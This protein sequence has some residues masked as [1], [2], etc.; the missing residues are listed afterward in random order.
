MNM[1]RALIL[2]AGIFVIGALAGT[3]IM[4]SPSDDFS[5][6]P[7][8]KEPPGHGVVGN[9]KLDT[10][11]FDVLITYTDG[12]FS[13]AD[14]SIAQGQRV[15]FLDASKLP[16]WPASGVHPTH[17]LYPEK[18]STDCLGSSFDACTQLTTGEF[19]DFTFYYP[20]TWT[21]HDHIHA[22]NTGSITVTA[23][24]SSNQ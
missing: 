15:R 11:P 23:S 9:A 14:I 5:Y 22:Y 8:A 7:P 24:T 18:E 4:L 21:F 1:K 2:T 6:T 12:G 13:P 20:G 17:S 3:Y 16:T 10:D 19:Y